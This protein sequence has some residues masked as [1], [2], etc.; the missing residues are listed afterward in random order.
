M[1]RATQA[2]QPR[3]STFILVASIMLLFLPCGYQKSK[4]VI[5]LGDS[6]TEAGAKSNGY[7]RILEQRLKVEGHANFNL[8]G[9][10]VGGNMVRHLLQRFENDV[11]QERP[12]VLF[13]LV[14]INDVGF[15][16]WHPEIGGTSP[17]Q[18]RTGL[19]YM[20]IRA[21]EKGIRVVLCTP[22]V[23][24][25][26]PNKKNPLDVSLDI[27]ASLV[28]EVAAENKV[29]LCDLRKAFTDYLNEHNKEGKEKVLTTDYV[30][31]NAKG[32][33][34]IAASMYAFLGVAK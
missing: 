12:D 29:E 19:Q 10:G 33:S 17:N 25:E 24:E 16:T 3:R 20:V 30:H 6:L 23:I 14:G 8:V 15:A 7:I 27:Y 28:R 31:M 9:K 11:V 2:D 34:L 5:F 13:I 1:F 32:D 4:K 22:T 21:K 26:K 18:F